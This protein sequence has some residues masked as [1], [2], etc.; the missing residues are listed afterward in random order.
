MTAKYKIKICV[1]VWHGLYFLFYCFSDLVTKMAKTK[2]YNGRESNV[3][4]NLFFE[5]YMTSDAKGK[6]NKRKMSINY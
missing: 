2:H 1:F 5:N 6:T 4:I 3:A